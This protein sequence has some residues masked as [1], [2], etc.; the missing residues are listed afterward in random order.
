MKNCIDFFIFHTYNFQ[1][2]FKTGLFFM[3]GLAQLVR[4]LD[5]GSRGRGFETHIPPHFIGTFSYRWGVAK[6]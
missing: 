3:V 5:C 6:R 2:A 4:A 1:R